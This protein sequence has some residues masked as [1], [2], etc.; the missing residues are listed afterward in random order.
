MLCSLIDGPRTM[1]SHVER[2]G[3]SPPA[4]HPIRYLAECHIRFREDVFAGNRFLLQLLSNLF[5]EP[6][7]A[8][9]GG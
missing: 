9:S 8:S 1:P 7:I 3:A 6:A 2:T 4:M 5:G